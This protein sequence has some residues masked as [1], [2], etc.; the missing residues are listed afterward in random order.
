[1]INA[2]V[3]AAGESARMGKPKPLL[4]FGDRTFLEQMIAVLE[5]AR[6]D[7][8]TVVLGARARSIEKAVDLSEVDVVVNRAYRD[9]Q[10]SSL[11]AGL[12]NVPSATEAIL[13]CLADSPF[14]TADTV[15]QIVAT[16]RETDA[17]IVIPT[18][19]GRR[20]H[21]SLFA[22]SM[23]ELLKNAPCE[24]GARYVVHANEERIVEV[25]TSEEAVVIGI[26]SPEDY[27]FYFGTDP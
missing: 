9:G 12:E 10:L 14:I 1:M 18:F 19:R 13:L 26:N 2:I 15:N 17:S 22:R 25:E 6:V 8:I 7:R 5:N 21:P 20:G 3:L 16:F 11:V 24:E 27:R 4:R 23:F